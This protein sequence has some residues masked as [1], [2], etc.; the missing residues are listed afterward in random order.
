MDTH[1][2]SQSSNLDHLSAQAESCT[3]TPD[4]E[5]S[6]DEIIARNLEAVASHFHSEDTKCVEQALEAFTEDIVWEAPN[7]TGLDRRVEGK[8][9]LRPFYRFLFETMKQVEFQHIERFATLDR[10]VDDSLCTFEVCKEG[11]WPD[12]EVGQRV[13]MR[14]VHIFDMRDGKISKEKVFEMRK[15]VA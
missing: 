9:A 14:I 15:A 12:Y 11:F 13:H 7:P 3:L 2:P 10:V 4:S 8:A 5:L 1:T 6:H